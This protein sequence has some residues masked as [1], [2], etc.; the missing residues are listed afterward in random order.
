MARTRKAWECGIRGSG[1]SDIYYAPT[2][3]KARYQAFLDWNDP[4]PDLKIMDIRVS[5]AAHCDV[6]LP[7]PHRLVA[8]LSPV[9]RRFIEHAFGSVSRQPGYRDHYCAGIAEP[10][11]LR[12]T[13]ELG[14]FDGPFGGENEYGDG[15]HWSGVFFYLTDLGKQVARSMLPEYRTA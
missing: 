7:E 13:Y 8:E 3:S 1:G 15:V 9:E 10:P 4:Y 2:A 6:E 12:L 11:L 14:I 5:R